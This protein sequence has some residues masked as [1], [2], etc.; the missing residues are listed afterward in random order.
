M[1]ANKEDVLKQIK[2]GALYKAYHAP[3]N[4]ISREKL[5]GEVNQTGQAVDRLS[6]LVRRLKVA[7]MNNAMVPVTVY[8]DSQAIIGLVHLALRTLY[9]S[10]ENGQIEN[11]EFQSLFD[12]LAGMVEGLVE[13][14]RGGELVVMDDLATMKEGASTKA[15]FKQMVSLFEQAD[16]SPFALAKAL[17]S[18]QTHLFIAAE[19][20]QKPPGPLSEALG[21][22][23]AMLGKS[24]GV[25]ECVQR[26]RRW[27]FFEG[28]SV[29]IA[30]RIPGKGGFKR[31]TF[32]SEKEHD[33]FIAKLP[34]DA[35]IRTAS[36][37]TTEAYVME[38]GK[39]NDGEGRWDGKG[40]KADPT[41]PPLLTKV[42]GQPEDEP[43]GEEPDQ[44]GKVKHKDTPEIDGQ[45]TTK[46]GERILSSIEVELKEHGRSKSWR[47]SRGGVQL[48]VLVS[49][50][51]ITI[52]EKGA[53]RTQVMEA[54]FGKMCVK[55]RSFGE[56]M[57]L[58]AKRVSA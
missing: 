55:V 5:A 18:M 10:A 42:P 39:T 31:K 26:I 43:E 40:A 41:D 54:R 14:I 12:P 33:A 34:D 13:T 32:K 11:E 20:A 50:P 3:T 57:N 29:E 49:K 37:S 47:A 56:F 1:P 15:Y 19:A 2:G 16:P 36:D 25:K 7:T 48:G 51:V 28:Y 35:E 4:E 6:D 38:A 21:G 27:K 17:S 58:V 24:E 22:M 46:P 30:Y 23:I 45:K 8:N 52:T 44:E 9:A 53:V